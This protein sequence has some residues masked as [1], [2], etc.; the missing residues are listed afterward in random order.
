MLFDSFSSL[1]FFYNN[2]F[3]TNNLKI[4]SCRNCKM[5]NNIQ[6]HIS[7]TTITNPEVWQSL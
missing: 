5:S 2:L 6:N 7:T 4:N 3:N 1:V